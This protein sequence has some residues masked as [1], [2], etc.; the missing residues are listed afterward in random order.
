MAEDFSFCQTRRKRLLRIVAQG[1]KKEM[2]YKCLYGACLENDL[3]RARQIVENSSDVRALLS[4]KG[5]YKGEVLQVVIQRGNLEMVRFFMSNEMWISWMLKKETKLDLFCCALR[6]KTTKEVAVYLFHQF[7]EL[8]ERESGE[9]S[10]LVDVISC[11]CFDWI[12]PLLEKKV[13][14][15]SSDLFS[16]LYKFRCCF[17]N[18]T[19]PN[20]HILH[21]ILQLDLSFANAR[22]SSGH[23]PL[24]CVVCFLGDSHVGE[25]VD[26]LLKS[27]VD[28]AQSLIDLGSQIHWGSRRVI[29][30]IR[31]FMT[32]VK[33]VSLFNVQNHRG[34]TLLM[35]CVKYHQFRLAKDLIAKGVDVNILNYRGH[36]LLLILLGRSFYITLERSDFLHYLLFELK[37]KVDQGYN[38]FSALDFAF[39]LWRQG[40][41]FKVCLCHPSPRTVEKF[42]S[43]RLFASCKCKYSYPSVWDLPLKF[44]FTLEKVIER[45]DG[46]GR[47]P[48]LVATAAG[49][50]EAVSYLLEQNADVTCCDKKGRNVFLLSCCT[51]DNALQN[52]LL[53]HDISS[54]VF[55]VFHRDVKGRNYIQYVEEYQGRRKHALI[56]RHVFFWMFCRGIRYPGHFSSLKSFSNPRLFDRQLV[57]LI[58]H[59][60]PER[61]V[62]FGKKKLSL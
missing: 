60:V 34:E 12:E 27:K 47:T 22:N 42:L 53:I 1:K 24:I 37:I 21:K 20:F 39:R 19:V 59:F 55:D 44:P 56:S 62:R 7:Y 58:F 52:F 46:Q 33:D 49:H 51:G 41:F 36:N 17:L 50:I 11:E 61:C 32:K 2:E 4:R 54:S 16:L 28:V 23:T 38:R 35:Q 18:R 6:N 31:E 15:S 5:G 45:R 14:F 57:R 48:L 10:L 13:P 40:D 25:M 26:Y 43:R 9:G 8:I 30:A 3:N 29:T